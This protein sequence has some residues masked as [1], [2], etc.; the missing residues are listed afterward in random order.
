MGNLK[1][2]ALYLMA[3]GEFVGEQFPNLV[4]AKETDIFIIK[5]ML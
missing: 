5:V 2:N 1:D 3:E 4:R